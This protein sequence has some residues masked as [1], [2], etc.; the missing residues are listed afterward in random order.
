MESET[1]EFETAD[2]ITLV[3]DVIVPADARAAA[4]VCHPH[5]Q[6][7]GNRHN[8]VVEA[9]YT[10]LADAGVAALRFDF[11]ASFDDGR[12]ERVDAEAALAEMRRRAAHAATFALG[13]SFGA[14]IA[15]G[16]TDDGLAGKVL[17]APPLGHMAGSE[18]GGTPTLVLTPTHDQ[19]TP[20]DVAEPIVASWTGSDYEVIPSCDHFLAGRASFVAE[21]AVRWVDERL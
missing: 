3:G 20:P 9:L 5:P 12:G 16:L 2:G 19:F 1:I 11:R 10:H 4:I 21:R 15:L 8:P 14:M 6:Y 7:G 18:P 17:V 13:Y